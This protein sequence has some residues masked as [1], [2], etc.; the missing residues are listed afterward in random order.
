MSVRRPDNDFVLGPGA[1]TPGGLRRAWGGRTPRTDASKGR[2]ASSPAL[3]FIRKTA[4]RNGSES[5]I[6]RA[7]ARRRGTEKRTQ[8][9][10]GGREARA[11]PS[12][13]VR[14]LAAAAR[15]SHSRGSRCDCVHPSVTHFTLSPTL[16]FAP[17]PPDLIRE[18][19]RRQFRRRRRR[20][21]LNLPI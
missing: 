11:R 7:S 20:M 21:A 19:D 18:N 4:S 17:L 5:T 6:Q 2:N 1:I 15:L 13:R 14:A 10:R 16:P 12:G 8:S 3:R 9:E